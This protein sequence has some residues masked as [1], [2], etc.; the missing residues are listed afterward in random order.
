[1][2]IILRQSTAGQEVPL[3][4]FLDT[5]DG[6]SEET[7]L[8]IANTDILLWKTG[9][10]TL[11]SKNSGGATH[12]SDGIYYATLDASDTNTVGSM[13]IFVHVAGALF[14]TLTCLVLPTAVYDSLIAGSDSLTVDLNADQSAATVGTVSTVT[15]V[16]ALASTAVDDILDAAVNTHT[17]ANTVG[18]NINVITDMLT[19]KV[20]ISGVSMIHYKQDGS[21]PRKTFTLDSTSNPTTKVPT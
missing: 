3:G 7:G 13:K 4:P 16:S 5:T 10:T 11:A 15:S 12:I 14:C 2:S 8:T 18:E 21:T 1:M 20:A 17:T 6:D 19:G 9:G